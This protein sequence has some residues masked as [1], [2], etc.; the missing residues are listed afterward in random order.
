MDF[1]SERKADAVPAARHHQIEEC[2]MSEAEYQ[3]KI[4]EFIGQLEHWPKI[5]KRPY[6]YPKIQWFLQGVW[7]VLGCLLVLPIAMNEELKRSH[8]LMGG[9]GLFLI[10]C[11]FTMRVVAFTSAAGGAVDRWIILRLVEL[12]EHTMFQPKPAAD[13]PSGVS[14]K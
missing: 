8:V 4:R 1:A 9:S 12:Q 11:A 3:Q 7:S 10:G 6:G 13:D 2:P 14:G 5:G